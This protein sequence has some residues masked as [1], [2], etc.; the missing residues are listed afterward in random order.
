[1]TYQEY[2]KDKDGEIFSPITSADSIYYSGR[3]QF[4]FK[5]GGDIYGNSITT[6]S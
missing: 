6:I 3:Y 4:R 1:M 2:L 5:I